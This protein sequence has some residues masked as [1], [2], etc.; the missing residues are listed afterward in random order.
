MLIGE[1]NEVLI[2]N[3]MFYQ[4][5]PILVRIAVYFVEH[6]ELYKV[7]QVKDIIKLK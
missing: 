4:T 6:M 3:H 5:I 1:S 7:L 2:F